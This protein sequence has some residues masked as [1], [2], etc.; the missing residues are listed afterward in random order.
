MQREW[1][2]TQLNLIMP[3][4]AQRPGEP[5]LGNV[6]HLQYSCN[7]NSG[8]IVVFIFDEM[9]GSRIRIFLKI[10]PELFEA[11]FS[12]IFSDQKQKPATSFESAPVSDQSF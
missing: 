7:P 5:T 1:V 2:V 4:R 12:N 10:R 9:N 3:R 6:E 11:Q 8:L